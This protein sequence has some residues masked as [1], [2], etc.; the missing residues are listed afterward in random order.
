MPTLP[1]AFAARP[2]TAVVTMPYA[3]EAEVTEFSATTPSATYFAPPLLSLPPSPPSLKS[4]ASCFPLGPPTLA[5]LSPTPTVPPLFSLLVG[6]AALL[7]CGFP[8]GLPGLR[9]P[10][11][12]P[13]LPSSARLPSPPPPLRWRMCSTK[14]NPAKTPFWTPPHRWPPWAPP[15]A[16]WSWRPAEE[17]GPLPCEK[18]SLGFPRSHALCAARLATPRAPRDVSLRIAQRISC[19][20]HRGKRA[21]FLR[22]SSSSD[23]GSFCSTGDLVGGSG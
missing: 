6:V 23:G 12:S 2:S 18:S 21:C 1:A 17:G 3:A 10:G 14:S 19:S 11:T 16:L 5:A 8:A 22:R 13:F 9:R 20:L 15:S 7:T 4:L